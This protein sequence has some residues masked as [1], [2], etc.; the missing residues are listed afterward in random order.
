MSRLQTSLPMGKS[1][2]NSVGIIG[3][4]VWL[5]RYFLRFLNLSLQSSAETTDFIE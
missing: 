5:S 4:S 2:R 1:L 3:L